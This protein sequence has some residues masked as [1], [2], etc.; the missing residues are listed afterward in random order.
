MQEGKKSS[1]GKGKRAPLAC[2]EDWKKFPKIENDKWKIEGET[3]Y[4]ANC[5]KTQVQLCY[6]SQKKDGCPVMP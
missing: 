4:V 6:N 3:G 1:P 2:F 5:T